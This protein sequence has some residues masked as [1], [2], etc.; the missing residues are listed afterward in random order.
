MASGEAVY[1][2]SVEELER[3]WPHLGPTVRSMGE[4]ARAGL[5]VLLED[6]RRGGVT[7]GWR[8]PPA[9]DATERELIETLVAMLG[10]ALRRIRRSERAAEA[11]FGQV[12]EA[13]LDGVAVYRA[14]RDPAGVVLDFELRFFNARAADM[15]G[16]GGPYVG[17]ALTDVYP[18]A[19]ESGLLD[20]LVRVLETGEPF[21]RDPFRFTVGDGVG[22][23][24]SI[25]ASRQD[26]DTIVLVVRDVT[27]RERVQ[28]E[29]ELA[30]AEA[31]RRKTVVDELQRA[32]LPEHLPSLES[33]MLAARYVPAEQD[34][35]VGGD[36]YDAFTTASGALVLVV[37]DVAG[38]GVAAS[39]LMSMIR[40]AIRAYAHETRS[41]SE[42]L[43]RADRLVATV[44][45]FATCWLAS[46]DPETGVFT[47]ANA[48]HPPALVVGRE[49]TRFVFGE[50]DAPLGLATRTRFERSDVLGEKESLVLY[51]DGLI[52][53]RHEALTDGLG[54]LL[55]LAVAL[56]PVA[57]TLA[58]ELVDGMPP[59][60]G[61][62]D[63]LCVLVLQRR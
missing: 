50:P 53:R 51:S 39:G 58:D 38:H 43:D 44:E 40:S 32:F 55:D 30:I 1:L 42:I 14:I 34:S 61:P 19:R 9:F 47:W 28:R 33:H 10:S 5:P 8:E 29:R 7:I 26:A 56:D 31:S 3:R 36:W 15:D 35:P 21:I 18:P 37:G 57:D 16:R 4:P 48:G 13:M 11:E 24:A 45:G 46:Y 2:R 6:G 62:G 23:P 60:P 54:R 49:A 20:E 59:G 17:R 41:P 52:E 12:L 22:R 63:D 25:A 27:E